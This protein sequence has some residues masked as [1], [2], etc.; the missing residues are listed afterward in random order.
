MKKIIL[1]ALM[2]LVVS[3]IFFSCSKESPV[4]KDPIAPVTVKPNETPINNGRLAPKHFGFISG[5]LVPA[6]VKASIKAFND[7]NTFETTAN[8]DGSFLVTDVIP[9]SYS[10]RIDYV[11]AGANDYFSTTIP[12]V[13]VSPGTVTN[14]GNIYVE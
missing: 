7:Y 2:L 3:V 1:S 4:T 11:P 13:V 5:I 10:V 6:P 12:K 8:A 9:G 14:L